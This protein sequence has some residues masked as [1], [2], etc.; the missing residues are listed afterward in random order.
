MDS[1]KPNPQHPTG[2]T[3]DSNHAPNQSA[4]TAADASMDSAVKN[5]DHNEEQDNQNLTHN[6]NDEDFGDN[7]NELEKESIKT[8][9]DDESFSQPKS[10]GSILAEEFVHA[11]STFKRSYGSIFTSALIAGLEIGISF[12]MLLSVYALLVDLMPTHYA[13]TLASLLYPVGFIAVV[14]GQSILYTEQTSLLSLPVVA[15]I[16]TVTKL[17]KLW[18]VVI[19]GNIVGGCIFS[20][21]VVW[22]GLQMQW[23]E[24]AHIKFLAHHV[25]DY[26]WWILLGS[27][28]VAGWMMGIAAWLVTS[29]RDTLSR[30][31]L[32]ALITACIGVLGLH[33]SIVGNIEV[34][35]G[36]LFGDTSILDYIRFL[37]LAL[38]G[39]TIGGVV[40]VTVLKFGS[41][42]YDIKKLK[43]D[44][45]EEIEA[46][47]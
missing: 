32:V 29:A 4:S 27:A 12:I 23:F 3:T 44:S 39:N 47:R 22:L 42:K 6:L 19:V 41:L 40:F 10:Y 45:L 33:H 28:I 1:S 36:V 25:L 31:L 14:I 34:F 11:R 15:G 35:S 5:K 37:L 18:G 30:V 13:L 26:S 9:T 7:V 8:L 21:S 46:D 24:V 43:E 20:L 2:N 17:T 16:E 38:I